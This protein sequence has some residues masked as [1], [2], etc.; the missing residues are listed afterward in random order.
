MVVQA[1]KSGFLES[2]A[3][4]IAS[5][6]VYAEKSFSHTAIFSTGAQ[7]W[8]LKHASLALQINRTFG[9]LAVIRTRAFFLDCNVI[10]MS[11]YSEEQYLPKILRTR[12]A[13]ST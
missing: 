5:L 7:L 3:T 4:R 1:L 12:V 9:E 13:I 2:P 11:L 10:A 8:G 6:F